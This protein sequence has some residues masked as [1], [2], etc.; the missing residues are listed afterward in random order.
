MG[1]LND[2]GYLL[3]TA[4]RRQSGEIV[5]VAVRNTK[6]MSVSLS[7]DGLPPFR[8][9][10]EFGGMGKDPIWQI[11]DSKIAG[12]LEAVQDSHTHVSILPGVTMRL[13]KYEMA[14]AKT[15]NDWQRVN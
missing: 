12:D 9:P 15:Q 14:L 2:E 8:K 7:I 6:G 11:D 3:A 4:Q 1:F 10:P 13:D 5:T